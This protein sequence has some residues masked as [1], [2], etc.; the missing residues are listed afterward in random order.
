MG[1]HLS[2]PLFYDTV[3]MISSFTN[4]TWASLEQVPGL[5]AMPASWKRLLGPAFDVFHTRFLHVNPAITNIP[6]LPTEHVPLELNWRQFGGQLADAL[7]C[8]RKLNYSGFSQAYQ[9]GTWSENG[10]PVFLSI[11]SDERD[12]VQAATGLAAFLR[13]RFILFAPT[14]HHL[15]PLVLGILKSHDAAFFSLHASLRLTDEGRL[16]ALQAPGQMFASF[17]PPNDDDGERNAKMVVAALNRLD[18]QTKGRKAPAS[19]VLRLYCVEGLEPDQIA[20]RCRCARSLVYSRLNLLRKTL[21]CDP[22][23]LRRQSAHLERLTESLVDPRARRIHTRAAI[24]DEVE[25][26]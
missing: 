21:G 15:T 13:Q 7:E 17:N 3:Y 24:Y 19:M 11:N 2:Y 23:E 1:Q 10:I 4:F 18:P 6:Q 26:E 12:F 8:R 14:N 20:D 5:C 22:A 9:I 25:D 16:L